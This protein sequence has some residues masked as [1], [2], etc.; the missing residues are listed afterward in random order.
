VIEY[1]GPIDVVV[2]GAIG[3]ATDVVVGRPI[4]AIVGHSG[5]D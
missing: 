5:E 1:G 2:G 3:A 4:A